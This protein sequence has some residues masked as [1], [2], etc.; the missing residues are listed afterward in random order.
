MS[1]FRFRLQ[2]EAM[3][4]RIVP[5]VITSPDPSPTT[6]AHPGSTTE[7]SNVRPPAFGKIE[8]VVDELKK[9]PDAKALLDL[10]LKNDGVVVSGEAASGA[11][12][13]PKRE[14][15]KVVV[16][17]TV[18]P[19]K[20]KSLSDAASGMLFELI[21]FRFYN[22]QLDLYEKVR[23]GTITPDKYAEEVERLTYDYIKKHHDIADKAVAAGQWKPEAD[24][25][26][27]DIKNFPTFASYLEEAKRSGHY[28][29]TLEGA[30]RMAPKSPD[31]DEFA[32]PD[33]GDE[34]NDDGFTDPTDGGDTS[35]DDGFGWGNDASMYDEIGDLAASVD[36]A[37]YTNTTTAQ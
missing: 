5:T 3:S 17:I 13:A 11:K 12:I 22:Q 25:Y 16:T 30:K 6:P 36:A 27:D 34:S 20:T 32:D 9:S 33:E 26:K 14:G 35:G 19:D 29:R 2:L 28:D 1:H 23:A 37:Y 24:T 18:D 8:E 10:F 21:R 15:D 31:N 7:P 4:D